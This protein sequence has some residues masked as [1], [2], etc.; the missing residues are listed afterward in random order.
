MIRYFAAHEAYIRQQLAAGF[1]RPGLLEEH[2][3]KIRWLQHERLV[4]LLVTMLVAVLFLFLY[5]LL[6]LASFSV[7][8]LILLGIVAILLAAYIYHYYRLENTVQRWYKLADEIRTALSLQGCPAPEQP[9][10]SQGQTL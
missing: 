2:L 9:L 8:V 10:D 3:I 1:A 7:L 6:L 4:H 5:G